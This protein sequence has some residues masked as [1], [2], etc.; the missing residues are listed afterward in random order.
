MSAVEPGG[1]VRPAGRRWSVPRPSRETVLVLLMAGGQLALAA[2]L[3]HG[4]LGAGVRYPLVPL[5]W[6]VLAAGFVATEAFVLH[7]QFKREA[8]TISI[9]ELPLVLGLFAAAPLQLFIGR[10]VGAAVTCL[11]HRRS[12]PLKTAWNLAFV[13]LHTAVAILVFRMIS[14][15]HDPKSVLTWAGAYAGALGANAVGVVALALVVAVYD[16]DLH[17]RRILRDLVT[18]DPGAPIM[19]TLALIAVV[20]LETT[21]HSALLLLLTGVGLLLAYR[22]YASL[23]DR[24]LNLERLYRFTQAVSS[25]PEVDEVLGNVLHEAKELL[26]SETAEALFVASGTGDV[27]RVRLGS[28]DRLRRSEEPRSDEVDWL[29][30]LV[31]TGGEPLLVPRG[32]RRPGERGRLAPPAA[33]GAR[34]GPPRGGG[35]ARRGRPVPP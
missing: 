16:G 29:L 23:A 34:G 20:C 19:V 10:L 27:A 8:Q 1:P 3:G 26:R 14:V 11:V 15:D 21:T 31:V 6:W 22:A 28:A 30:S 33:P 13:A 7:V 24:H 25:S 18:G 17:P 4:A 32:T 2:V 12:S 35:G 5:P 9:S